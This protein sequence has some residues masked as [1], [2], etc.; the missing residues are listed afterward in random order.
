MK[1]GE[2]FR[3]LRGNMTQE[4]LAKYSGV[5]K[6]ILSKIE[7]GKMTGTVNCH[8]KLAKVFGMKLSELYAYLEKDKFE[9]IEYHSSESKTDFYDEFF[10]ILTKKP[11]AKRMLPTIMNLEPK[12]ERFLV[13]TLKKV[14]R[15]IIVLEGKI[16]IELEK[17][18]YNLS[19][20]PRSKSGDSLYSLSSNKHRIKNIGKSI[21]YILCIS[22]PPVL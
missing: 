22:S 11:L 21:A 17:K 19:R 13:E 20:K 7:S 12:Q 10:E 14:E 2:K 9:P 18:V 6:A 5:D 16:E 15:F 3:L 4:E 8:K 1:R